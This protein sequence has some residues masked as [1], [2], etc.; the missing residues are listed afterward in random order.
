MIDFS[1]A[2]PGEA[3]P[4]YRLCSTCEAIDLE[5]L[6]CDETSQKAVG[7]ISKYN[8]PDCPFCSLV[9]EAVDR[10]WGIVDKKL[11]AG[12]E[13]FIQS[14]SPLSIQENGRT[15]HPQPR[16]LLATDREPPKFHHNQ[17]PLR[18]VD[19]EKRGYIIAEIES[20]PND[21]LVI[22]YLPRREIRKQVDITLVKDWLDECQKHQHS[23][24]SKDQ[25]LCNGLFQSRAPFRLIDVDKNCIAEKYERCDY[26]ALSYVW[27]DTP[28]ILDFESKDQTMTPILVA[29]RKNIKHLKAENSLSESETGAQLKARIPRTVKDAMEFTRRMGMRYLWVD[30]LCIIQN[31]GKNM[32]Q[33]IAQMGDIYNS[34]AVT[35]IAAAGRNSDAGLSGISPRAGCPIKPVT[36]VTSSGTVLSL[37]VCLSSL[38]EEVRRETWNTRGWTFQEQSLSQRC[39]YFTA[40][41]VFF[42]CAECQRREGYDYA[43]KGGINK[44]IE[45]EVRTGPPWWKRNLRRDLDPT[46]Y[47]YLGSTGGGELDAQTYQTAVQ[48]YTRKNLTYSDDI[49]NAFE[50]IFN[51]S[52]VTSTNPSEKLSIRQAQAIPS[53]LLYRALLWFP[54]PKAKRRG[55]SRVT[56]PIG[57]STEKFSLWSWV[58]WDGPVEFVFADN[59]WLPRKISQAP[60]KRVPLHVPIVRWY[61]GGSKLRHWTTDVWKIACEAQDCDT[62]SESASKEVD[63]TRDYLRFRVG[64]DVKALIEGSSGKRIKLFHRLSYG[65][66]GFFAPY[67]KVRQFHVT[68]DSG[69][70]VGKLEISGHLGEFRFDEG[71]ELIDELVPIVAANV[72]RSTD[73]QSILLGLTTRRGVSRR[74]GLGYVYYTDKDLPKPQWGYKFFRLK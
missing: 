52:E 70:Q 23:K 13:L 20:L 65:E 10:A 3:Q 27:G 22:N 66:L 32:A 60:V 48:E 14:R 38:C 33:L 5:A 30:T 74:V 37:S 24:Q 55:P 18:Q 64:I 47:H 44:N 8:D 11:A 73:A 29:C 45:I 63:R 25:C 28:T 42:N 56:G 9:S 71:D 51:R 61:Y 21:G 57:G 40:N 19:R 58:S 1:E 41:E 62:V 39:L 50:G 34:A 16:L 46:P 49:F 2:W 15:H 7:R 31:D 69:S 4:K 26:V 68:I 17:M 53:H 67:V 6:L 59:L 12:C 36:I 43:V 72:T 54:L 35:I